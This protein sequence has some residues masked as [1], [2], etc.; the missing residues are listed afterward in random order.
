MTRGL[1]L[2]ILKGV[3]KVSFADTVKKSGVESNKGV[4]FKGQVMLD[5]DKIS[6]S[7]PSVTSPYPTILLTPEY[8]ASLETPW[9]NAVILKVTGS[10][11][12]FTDIRNIIVSMWKPGGLFSHRQSSFGRTLGYI[13]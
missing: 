8:R 13:G 12:S 6:I 9:L 3:G 11:I 1:T 7:K 10:T 4:S 5:Y 2:E